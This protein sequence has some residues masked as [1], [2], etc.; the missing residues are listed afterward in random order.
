M[1]EVPGRG[2]GVGGGGARVGVPFW[3]CGLCEEIVDLYI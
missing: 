1:T 3:G 2:G